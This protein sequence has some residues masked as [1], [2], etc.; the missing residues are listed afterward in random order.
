[1]KEKLSDVLKRFPDFKGTICSRVREIVDEVELSPDKTVAGASSSVDE[2][3]EGTP[4][5]CRSVPLAVLR[6]DLSD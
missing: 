1:M 5:V 6:I 3:Q 4:T 2:A